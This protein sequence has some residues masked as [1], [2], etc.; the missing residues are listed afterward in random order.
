MIKIGTI[1]TSW[2]TESFADAITKSLKSSYSCAYS[3][4]ASNAKNFAKKNGAD[5]WTNDIET[6]IN[7]SDAIYV[8]SPNSI[9]LSQIKKILNSGV[10]VI[11]E[12]PITL[13]EKEHIEAL[14]IAKNNNL[15]LMQA[16]KTRH[17]KNFKNLKSFVKKTYNLNQNIKGNL[18]FSKPSSKLNEFTVNNIPNIFSQKFGGGALNDLG[19]YI[20]QFV[21]DLFAD[22][23][24]YKKWKISKV[25]KVYSKINNIDMTT[26][27]VMTNNNIN[28]SCRVSKDSEPIN[29]EYILIGDK[30]ISIPDV[31]K[32]TNSITNDTNLLKKISNPL[33]AEGNSLY[34]ELVFFENQIKSNSKEK[35]DYYTNLDLEGTKILEIIRKG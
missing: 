4:D 2:I 10:H 24:D 20:Y 3:R 21:I 29:S 11:C 6:L 26:S 32:I 16:Y 14:N 22:V 33:P 30:K 25:S 19:I 23:V 9:H 17:L 28:I 27:W 13:T 35:L 1:G 5:N 8:A 12:K 18:E 7:L 34:D 31:S 15:V